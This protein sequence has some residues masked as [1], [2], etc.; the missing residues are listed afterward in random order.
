VNH[1]ATGRALSPGGDSKVDGDGGEVD[2]DGGD[3]DGDGSRRTSPFWEGARTETSVPQNSLVVAAELRNSFWKIAD[4]P[5][6]FRPETLYRRRG[7]VRGLPGHPH[8]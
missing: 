3:S 4:P 8:T 1:I 7:I 6:V 2:G 5:R